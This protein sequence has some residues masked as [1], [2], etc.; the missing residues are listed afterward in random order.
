MREFVSEDEEQRRIMEMQSEAHEM[1][2]EAKQSLIMNFGFEEPAAE[3]RVTPQPPQQA[4]PS[5]T[6]TASSSSSSRVRK[7]VIKRTLK[8]QNSLGAGWRET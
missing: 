7:E 3:A 2:D 6:T 8:K 1:S 5:R 4:G